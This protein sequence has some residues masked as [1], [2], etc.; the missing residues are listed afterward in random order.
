ML[1]AVDTFRT[2]CVPIDPQDMLGLPMVD[3]SM[4]RNDMPRKT[5]SPST[6]LMTASDCLLLVLSLSLPHPSPT[7]DCPYHSSLGGCFSEVGN[8]HDVSRGDRPFS[9]RLAPRSLGSLARGAQCP[10]LINTYHIHI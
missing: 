4:W 2:D 7:Y 1:H 3:S 8:Q 9:A 10:W 6:T 5:R